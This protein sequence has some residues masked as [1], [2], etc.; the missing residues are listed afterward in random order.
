MTAMLN[1]VGSPPGYCSAPSAEHVVDRDPGQQV[2]GEVS[3]HEVDLEAVDPGGHRRVGR[4]DRARPHDLQRLGEREAVADEVADAL[5]AEESGVAL[6]G[7]EHLG[8]GRRGE[9]GEDLDRANTSDAEQQLLQQ[10]VLAAAAVEAVGDAAQFVHVLRDVGVEQQER[11]AADLHAPYARVERAAVGQR[12]R[13]LCCCAVG[14]PQHRERQPVGVEHGVALELPALARDR[15]T[16]VAGPVEEPD[17][18]DRHPEVAR[19]LEVVAGEDAEAAG[20]LRKRGGDAELR[21]EVGD[22][23][24]RVS[25]ATGTSAAARGTRA[26][27]RARRRRR[28]RRI[29]PRRALRDARDR[30]APRS[31]IGS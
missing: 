27:R 21:R 1:F 15:L 18:E 3:P 24:R 13:D 25:Q 10:A 20:V 23:R 12:E 26:G 14:M 30:R 28:R 2:A 22:R 8:H 5:E 29:R 16:E 7:V 31:A 6:V 19:R 11:D 4:E 17:P 9:L